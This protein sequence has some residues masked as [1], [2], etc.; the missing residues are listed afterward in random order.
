M[1]IGCLSYLKPFSICIFGK[2]SKLMWGHV[3]CG[4]AKTKRQLDDDQRGPD[5]MSKLNLFSVGSENTA[6]RPSRLR[7]RCTN[8][9]IR[10]V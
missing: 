4:P 10:L 6:E 2:F 8:H 9:P 5:R 3:V 7:I 1:S